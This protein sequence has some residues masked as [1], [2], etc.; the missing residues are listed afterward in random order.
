MD[1][2]WFILWHLF[3]CIV[4]LA[5]NCGI[6]FKWRTE[7]HWQKA[8]IYFNVVSS[9]SFGIQKSHKRQSRLP[10]FNACD[11]RMLSSELW[12]MEGDERAGCWAWQW[13]ARIE[14][15]IGKPQNR[16]ARIEVSSLQEKL[17]FH[18]VLRVATNREGAKCFRTVL[19]LNFR[20]P[21]GSARPEKC[22]WFAVSVMGTR[23][24]PHMRTVTIATRTV[25]RSQWQ[26]WLH[27]SLN[28][29]KPLSYLSKN[30]HIFRILKYFIS[31]K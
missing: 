25:Q 6:T 20:L 1:V 27:R 28:S 19:P 11:V 17:M 30:L 5:S 12:L 3:N 8:V 2:P 29:Y 24:C 4:H 22:R 16:Q 26:F 13:P 10:R 9:I 31:W 18:V 21:L 15:N 7:V 14:E 23:R